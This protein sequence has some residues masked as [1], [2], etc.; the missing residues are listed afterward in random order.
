MGFTIVSLLLLS[1]GELLQRDDVGGLAETLIAAPKRVEMDALLR[2]TYALCA[3][4]RR[5]PAGSRG[6]FPPRPVVTSSEESA[7]ANQGIDV[8]KVISAAQTKATEAASSL[9]GYWGKAME[10]GRSA[11]GKV[12]E[13][14]TE[15]RMQKVRD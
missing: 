3:F 1:R 5:C 7:F 11:A 14:L 6:A 12:S 8:D 9:L 4:E 15:E 10:A 13:Q 2:S